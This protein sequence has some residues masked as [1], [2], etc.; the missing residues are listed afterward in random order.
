[1][2][3]NYKFECFSQATRDIQQNDNI[4]EVRD[5]VNIKV[6]SPIKCLEVGLILRHQGMVRN[7]SK[8][9]NYS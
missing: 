7:I 5:G 2:V 8:E 9:V 3:M 6:Y 4:T 1:M